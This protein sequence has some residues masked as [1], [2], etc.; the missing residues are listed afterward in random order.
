MDLIVGG[1]KYGC[2]AV[3]YLRRNHRDFTLVDKD[4]NCLAARKYG[5]PSSTKVGETGEFFVKG[6]LAEAFAL[7]MKLKP[8]YVFPTAPIH[9]AAELAKIKFKLEPWTEPING[10]LINLPQAV[11]L[12][13]GRGN[14]IVSFNRDKDCFEK[15]NAPEVCPSTKIRRPCTMDRLMK[16]AYPECFLLIS[17]QM[18]P[19]MGALK[20]TEI[21]EF[22]NRAEKE[23]KFVVAT[24]CDCHG[25][26]TG[27]KKT[28]AL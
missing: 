25:V 26:F 22:L 13:V 7:I 6:D 15:C 23:E 16:F 28:N 19:G 5:I 10:I 2:Q 24:A 4:S 3:E 1:G 27:F 18:S 9:I 12:H 8:E 21:L 11:V 14:L 17:Y 20:G